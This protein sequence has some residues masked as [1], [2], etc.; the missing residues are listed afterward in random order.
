MRKHRVII[1]DDD[2]VI[3]KL[4]REIFLSLDY[5]VLTFTEP[6]VCPIY[7]ENAAACS[8]MDPCADIMITDYQMPVMSGLDLLETQ[9]DRGCKLTVKNK[10]LITGYANTSISSRV[11]ELGCAYFQKPMAL[12]S[13][14]AWVSECEARVDL[15]RP[16][17]IIRKESRFPTAPAMQCALTYDDHA[18]V[19]TALNVSE[20][21]CCLKLPFA[22]HELQAVQV[23][24]EPVLRSRPALVRWVSR[25][26]DGTYLA[27]LN[28]S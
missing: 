5:E 22:L 21:G 11:K 26:D 25:Q 18:T 20:S 14:L 9:Q 1:F 23:N 10:T 4:Y 15:S 16:L 6:V 7:G 8:K 17:G 13:L 19:C 2:P 24:A 28:C 27:G 3:V 12:S